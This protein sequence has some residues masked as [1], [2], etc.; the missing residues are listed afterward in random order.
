[1]KLTNEEFTPPELAL[2][3]AV[4]FT[5][6]TGGVFNDEGSENDETMEMIHPRW[7]DPLSD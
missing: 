6:T 3:P 7:D 4:S 2:K 1:M 5:P